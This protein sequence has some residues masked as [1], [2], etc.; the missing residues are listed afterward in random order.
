M[1]VFFSIFRH[2]SNFAL[3]KTLSPFVVHAGIVLLKCIQRGLCIA[4]ADQML[5]FQYL[6]T[7][8]KAPD[9]FHSL[10]HDRPV[11]SPE[12]EASSFY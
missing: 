8:D 2:T 3:H 6:A 1:I 12:L 4:M 9:L 11:P 10:F 7:G 5:P